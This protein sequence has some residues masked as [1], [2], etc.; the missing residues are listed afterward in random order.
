MILAKE[1]K[2]MTGDIQGEIEKWAQGKVDSMMKSNEATPKASKMDHTSEEPE[3]GK[4]HKLLYMDSVNQKIQEAKEDI[5][6]LH[7]V[8]NKPDHLVDLIL[9]TIRKSRSLEDKSIISAISQGPAVEVSQLTFRFLGI[10]N[11]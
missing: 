6:E 10:N 3:E 9:M 7:L 11:W 8:N 2:T 4:G 5:E 1:L